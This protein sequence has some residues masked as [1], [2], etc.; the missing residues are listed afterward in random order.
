MSKAKLT[1]DHAIKDA[2]EL[3]EHFDKVNTKPPPPHAEV[4]KRSGLI[5][6]LTAWETYVEDRV[7]QGL[8]AA[9]AATERNLFTDYVKA[10]FTED[11]KRFHNPDS[12]KTAKLFRD[13]LGIDVTK[14]WKWNGYDPDR[15]RGALD[16][17]VAKRGDAVH[18]SKPLPNGTPAK[19]LVKRDD[20]TKAIRFLRDL[21]TATE[22]ALDTRSS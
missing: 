20:L 9:I 17:L 11:M 4:L 10:R 6:A 12:A 15:A 16:E 8:E 2:Q 18:R 14:S 3:L 13:F 1:F 7:G 5:M 22:K 19:H 21:V